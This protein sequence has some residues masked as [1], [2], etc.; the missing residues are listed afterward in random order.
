MKIIPNIPGFAKLVYCLRYFNKYKKK[1]EN[2]ER[3]AIELKKCADVITEVD[4]RMQDIRY[5][6]DEVEKKHDKS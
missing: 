3:I 6:I 5:M 1:I 2:P 4:M